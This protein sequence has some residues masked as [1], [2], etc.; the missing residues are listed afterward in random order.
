MGDN[1]RKRSCPAVSQI[2]NLITLSSAKGELGTGYG[3]SVEGRCFVWL[4]GPRGRLTE[5]ATL[6]QEGGTCKPIIQ[7][8]G[9][10]E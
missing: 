10:I 5:T 3:V 9:T 8:S 4:S 1:D 2:S 6:R 7:V